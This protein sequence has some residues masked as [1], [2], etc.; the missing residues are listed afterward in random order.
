MKLKLLVLIIVLA[1]GVFLAS[2]Q[3]E[4]TIW[5]TGGENDSL[6]LQTAAAGFTESTG[7]AVKV[8]PV[9]W[10][11]AYARFLTAVNAGEGAD[12]FAGGM[13]WGI[14][15]GDLG[16]LINLDEA[17]ADDIDDLLDGNNAEFVN[18]IIG[19]DGAVYGVPYDEAIHV[20]YYMPGV[21]AEAGIDSAP[22]TW[23]ELTEALDALAEAGLGGGGFGWGN[24]GWLGFQPFVAQAGGAWYTPDCSEAAINSDEGLA[25]LEFF[26]L[27][28]DEYG[29]PQ[30]QANIGVGFSTGELA[31]GIDGSWAA[32]GLNASYPELEGQWA[33]AT[34]P[35]GPGGSGAA[36]IGGKM[37]GVFSYSDKLDQAWQFIQWLQTR[38]SADAIAE[39]AYNLGGIH[40]P[41][42]INSYDVIRGEE[43]GV[44]EVLAAQ[45]ED[46]TAPPH[47]A[48]WEESGFD[49][50]L[51]LQ[52]V[53]F[54]GGDFEEALIEMADILDEALD[55]YGG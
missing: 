35:M 22:A 54:E 49:L 5:M 8:E 43:L 26:T 9:G 6:V 25:A 33:V 40:L 15:L 19:T 11:E 12:M 18:A 51:V 55:E 2:A 28:Y 10:G 47:C 36:F 46:V 53:L 1:A 44:H 24:A 38:D 37:A 34:L 4:L 45:L 20:M 14:S 42:Q 39:Q 27:L 31:I 13:S 32:S 3:D 21:L 50:N 7:I 52:N 17:Y 16:G 30:E 29:F 41:P 48:G 23:D